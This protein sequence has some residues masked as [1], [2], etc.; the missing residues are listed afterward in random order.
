[1]SASDLSRS[2]IFAIGEKL[3]SDHFRG[4]VWLNMLT[5]SGTACPIGNVTFD[6]DAATTGINTPVVRSCL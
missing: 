5:P 2:V 6:R 4:T 3:K 1:M